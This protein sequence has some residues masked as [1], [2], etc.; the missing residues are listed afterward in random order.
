ME[1]L[2]CPICQE[3]V[4]A[5]YSLYPCGHIFCGVC[6]AGW[7][8]NKQDCP[9][10]R[11]RC[12]S[13][14]TRQITIDNVVSM[15]IGNLNEMDKKVYTERKKEWEEQKAV[16]EPKILDPKKFAAA[17]AAAAGANGYNRGGS[18]VVT[19]HQDPF[20][21]MV[22]GMMPGMVGAGG[23]GGNIPGL[24]FLLQG[25]G[26]ATREPPQT[27]YFAAARSMEHL[28]AAVQRSR[29][30]S[31]SVRGSEQ[32]FRCEYSGGAAERCKGCRQ[33]PPQNSLI[34]GVGRVSQTARGGA[35]NRTPGWEWYHFDCFPPAQ[36]R[37][38]RVFGFEGMRNLSPP[39]A[40][41]IRERMV[42]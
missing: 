5:A 12:T 35:G 34:L 11:Q 16:L 17:N 7:L 40:A 39:D 25:L 23:G 20:V 29:N 24:G 21:G 31:T 32:R 22:P 33:V 30:P 6:I 15:S 14:P 18:R 26:R 1:E 28:H 13:A 2:T 27:D 19:A 4:V 8:V 41:R 9:N 38:A 10:C 3:L 36:F 42:I 37:N